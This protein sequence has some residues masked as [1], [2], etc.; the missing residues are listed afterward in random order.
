MNEMILVAVTALVALALGGCSVTSTP[1][2]AVLAPEQQQLGAR[3]IYTSPTQPTPQEAVQNFIS[4]GTGAVPVI[5]MKS[6]RLFVQH[7][8]D[9]QTSLEVCMALLSGRIE[10]TKAERDGGERRSYYCVPIDDGR[11]GAPAPV[12]GAQG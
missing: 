5:I 10:K 8:F 12:P 4:S 2:N 11:P 1:G 3:R 6:D 7:V 9:V